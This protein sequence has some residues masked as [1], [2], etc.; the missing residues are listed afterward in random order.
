MSN[1]PGKTLPTIKVKGTKICRHAERHQYMCSLKVYN[2][3]FK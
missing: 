3:G 1:G 2:A